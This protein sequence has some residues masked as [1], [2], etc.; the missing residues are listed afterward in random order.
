MQP[1]AVTLLPVEISAQ[2]TET[3]CGPTCLH[4]LY[5]FYGYSIPLA[6][7]IEEVE[8]VQN[9]GT[10]AV[11]LGNHAL[12]NGFKVTMYSFNL[13]I[14]DPS[15]FPATHETLAEK[16]KLSLKHRHK[17]K[18]RQAIQAYIRFCQLG[19]QVRMADLNAALLRKYLNQRIPILTGLSSTFLYRD[20]RSDP[21]TNLMM[22]WQAILKATLC[23]S[24]GITAR[25]AACTFPTLTV[26]IL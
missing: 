16:L 19:G 15:W 24:Q 1:N 13:R 7:I 12:A 17:P 6:T 22:I 3:S 5:R 4:A 9:G 23:C 18:M 14:L 20:M 26:R 10:L 2:P 8:S 11:I 21:V 25:S